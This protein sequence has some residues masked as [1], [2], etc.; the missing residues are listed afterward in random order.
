MHPMNLAGTSAIRFDPAGTARFEESLVAES[1]LQ[2]V[3][4]GAPFAV[5]MRTPGDDRHLIRGL[6][7]SEGWLREPA[8]PLPLSFRPGEGSGA[9][10]ADLRLP[11]EALF[12]GWEASR[13]LLSTA[14]CG[15]CGLRDASRLGASAASPFPPLRFADLRQS[16]AETARRIKDL[17]ENQ[18][19]HARTGGAHG[20]AIFDSG[21]ML[22]ALYE[23]AGRHNAVDKAVG[24]LLERDVLEHSAILAVSGRVSFEIVWKAR[25]AGLRWV[26]AVSAPTS[27]AVDFARAE[28]MSLAGFCRGERATVYSGAGGWDGSPD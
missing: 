3:L 1:A 13:S 16:A 20:A 19:L 21:G 24:A 11:A 28:G 23:D 8:G 6:L 4:N 10:I 12:P 9:A 14:A 18:P 22:M 2:I 26:L 25:R 7:H 27:L 5:V 17:S 15:I